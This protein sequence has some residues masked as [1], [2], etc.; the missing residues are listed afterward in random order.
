MEHQLK[1]VH[2]YNQYVNNY[3]EKFM[4]F[5]LYQDTFDDILNLLPINGKV[6]ELG[7]GPGNVINYF[8]KKEK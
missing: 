4:N 5:D 6:C 3:I 7:C 1:T 8:F 2:I